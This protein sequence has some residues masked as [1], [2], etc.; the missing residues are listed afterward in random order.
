MSFPEWAHWLV[1]GRGLTADEK[2]VLV[3]W[4]N[5]YGVAVWA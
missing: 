5:K 3:R 2:A 1:N 4:L